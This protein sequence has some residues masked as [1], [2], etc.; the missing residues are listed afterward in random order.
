[1]S[2]MYVEASW[3]NAAAT[4][5]TADQL[6]PAMSVRRQGRSVRARKNATHGTRNAFTKYT[7]RRIA[8]ASFCAGMIDTTERIASMTSADAIGCARGRAIHARIADQTD[9]HDCVWRNHRT[10]MTSAS[11][12]HWLKLSKSVVSGTAMKRGRLA[13]KNTTEF[14]GFVHAAHRMSEIVS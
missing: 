1:M 14:R 10:A 3:T 13:A 5:M 4:M 7:M 12:R 8:A 9:R 6:T 2:I 11:T